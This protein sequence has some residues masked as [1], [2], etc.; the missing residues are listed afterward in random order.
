MKALRE[1]TP[2]PIVAMTAVIGSIICWHLVGTLRWGFRPWN[3][4]MSSSDHAL[5]FDAMDLLQ[6]ATV[7]LA[8]F[9]V[10]WMSVSIWRRRT[11][12]RTVA[13][14]ISILCLLVAFVP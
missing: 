11:R 1:F 13:L 10:V 2:S 3:L 5:I 12:W 9:A 7:G 4:Q 8:L 6:E 14:V